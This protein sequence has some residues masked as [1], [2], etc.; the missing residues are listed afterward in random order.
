[1]KSNPTSAEAEHALSVY[2]RIMSLRQGILAD[3]LANRPEAFQPQRPTDS[4]GYMVFP[5]VLY[6]K[7]DI[8][9]SYELA[10][11]AY[12]QMHDWHD[13]AIVYSQSTVI[14][15]DVVEY[16]PSVQV[17]AATLVEVFHNRIDAAKLDNDRR[18]ATLWARDAVQFWQRQIEL[19]PD[20]PYLSQLNDDA[21]K[22]DAEVARWLAN[23]STQP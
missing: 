1:M 5:S 4:E 19:H 17:F 7:C 12:R 2:H 16:S 13:L 6:A 18:N 20:V 3:L 23:P 21:V 10:D 11:A 15:K 8:G 22:E 9:W 14:W